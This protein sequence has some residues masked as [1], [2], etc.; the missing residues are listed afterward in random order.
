MAIQCMGEYRAYLSYSV[1]LFINKH[2][3][4]ILDVSKTLANMGSDPVKLLYAL[5]KDGACYFQSLLRIKH[6]EHLLIETFAL[7][8]P[9]WVL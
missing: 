3:L 4:L 6:F 9:Q 7:T 2:R 1:P 8:I 5:T